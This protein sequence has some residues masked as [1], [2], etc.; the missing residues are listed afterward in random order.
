VNVD[1]LE[2]VLE[3][4]GCYITKTDCDEIL[5]EFELKTGEE[6]NFEQFKGI[7]LCIH[8]S[9]FSA[10][11]SIESNHLAVPRP[12]IRR[13]SHKRLSNRKPSLIGTPSC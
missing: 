13:L 7:I 3:K 11:N 8:Y 6:M 4:A 5:N 10:E 1:D 2:Y 12:S 9:G